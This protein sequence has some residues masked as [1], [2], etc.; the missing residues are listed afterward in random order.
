MFYPYFYFDP[1][2]IILVPGILIALW[3]SINVNSTINT[4]PFAVATE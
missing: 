1:T 4:I 2:M 3:A